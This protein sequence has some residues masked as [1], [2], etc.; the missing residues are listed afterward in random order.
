MRRSF[1]LFSRPP[2]PTLFLVS[3]AL[4]GFFPARGSLPAWWFRGMSLLWK[5][6]RFA[7]AI[8]P[9]RPAAIPMWMVI[10]GLSPGPDLGGDYQEI[11]A[12]ER[13]EDAAA[14]GSSFCAAGRFLDR[15]SLSV[16]PRRL[17][18]FPAA[19]SR[20]VPPRD[21]FAPRTAAG[22]LEPTW[23]HR[24]A[25]NSREK[26]IPRGGL[27]RTYA[28]GTKTHNGERDGKF[29]VVGSDWLF[30]HF[31]FPFRRGSFS[32]ARGPPPRAEPTRRTAAAFRNPCE[33]HGGNS[34]NAA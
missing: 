20:R 11:S 2:R 17:L 27:R 24:P 32:P 18:V 33:K 4:R 15:T 5:P 28:G 7:G 21:A 13:R 30:R 1:L 3:L 9:L 29:E 31:S 6:P 12:G 23:Q 34:S 10:P 22:Q 14:E 8:L 26:G 25:G 16:F 19:R